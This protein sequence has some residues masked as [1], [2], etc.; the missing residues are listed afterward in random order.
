MFRMV[1]F[2]LLIALGIS[3]TSVKADSKSDAREADRVVTNWEMKSY[4]SDLYLM[5][6]FIANYAYAK[7]HPNTVFADDFEGVVKWTLI[8]SL[9]NQWYIGTA[10]ANGGLKSLYISDDNGVNNNY[11]GSNT[12]SHAVS[13]P[14][15]LA[16]GNAN[17]VLSFDWRAEGELVNI[18]YY[19]YLSVW[20]VPENYIPQAGTVITT[21]SSGGILVSR[22]LLRQSVFKKSNFVVDLSAFANQKVKIIF[23]WVNDGFT[24][25]QPPAAIDNVN[26]SLITCW[27]PRNMVIDNITE[28]SA[29]AQWDGPAGGGATDFEIYIS[30]LEVSPVYN[31][32]SVIAVNNNTSVNFNNL[33]A[34][35]A[36]NVWYRTVCGVTNKSYWQ[37][38]VSFRTPCQPLDLPFGETFNMDSNTIF[39]WKIV[40]A[41]N[42]GTGPNGY[43][44]WKPLSVDL[45]GNRVMYFNGG[46][47]NDDWLISPIFNMDVTKT[48]KLKY[49]YKTTSYQDNEFEVLA[50]DSGDTVTN[51]TQIIVPKKI[52]RNGDWKEQITYLTNIGGQLNFAWHVTDTTYAEVSLNNVSLEQVECIE[53]QG[54]SATN[55]KASQVTLNWHDVTN[56]SWQ[57]RI[58]GVDEVAPM[59]SGVTTTTNEVVVSQDYK[60]DPLTAATNYVYYVRALCASGNFG[61][62]IGP[63][64]FRTACNPVNLPLQEG[65]NSASTTL[66]C[67]VLLDHNDDGTSWG[68]NRWAIKD[69]GQYEGNGV[70]RFYAGATSGDHDD[71]LISPTIKMTGAIYSISY[72]YKTSNYNDSEF[73]LLLAED[74][75]NLSDFTTVLS[76]TEKYTNAGYLKKTVY[77]QGVVADVKLAWHVVGSGASDLYID[78]VTIERVDCIA[79][80]NYSVLIEQLGINTATLS[81]SDNT[82]SSWEYYVQPQGAGGPPVSSGSL[83]SQ[84][85]VVVTRTNGVGGANLQ[86]NTWYEFY[87]R[88]SCGP[89][90]NSLW[91]GPIAFKTQCAAV[92]LPFWEGFNRNSS[93]LDCWAIVDNNQDGDDSGWQTTNMWRVETFEPFQGDQYMHFYGSY[94]AT[95]HDDWLIS[96]TFILDVNKFYRLKY[97][98]KTSNYG[99]NDFKVLLSTTG[100]D[101]DKFTTILIDKQGDKTD[102]WVQGLAFVGNTGGSVNLAWQVNSDGGNAYLSLDNVFFEEVIGCPEPLDLGAK[103]EL[104]N[105]VTIYW[106]DAFGSNWEYFVQKK[107]GATPTTNGTLTNKKE[108]TI[109]TDQSA[110]ALLANAQYEFY[111]RTVCGNGAYSVW[112][113]PFVFRTDC[114]AFA[115]PYWEG[116]NG[117]STTINCWT[118]RDSE[119]EV[120][121]L[122]MGLPLTSNTW[123][124]VDQVTYEGSHAMYFYRSYYDDDSDA[125]LIS[126]RIR[127]DNNKIYR[128][129]YHFRVPEEYED[130]AY[131]VL[132]SNSGIEP[133]DFTKKILDGEYI[134]FN[135]TE[136]KIFITN[137]SGEVNI[138]WR[139]H[140]EESKVVYIDNVFVEEVIGCPEPLELDVDNIESKKATLLWSDAFN[141]TSWEYFVQEEG[142]GIPLTNGT[143]TA[144]KQNDITVDHSGKSL[145]PNTDYE[146][147]V[148]TV[149]IAGPHS[150]WAGP[151]KFQTLCDR[152]QTP[153]WDGFNTDTKTARCWTMVDA[154]YD[155]GGYSSPLL[156]SL[157]PYE[158]YE[159]NRGMSVS[160]WD[161]I[162][163]NQSNSWLISPNIVMDNSQYVLKYHYSTMS[164]YGGRFEVLLSSTPGSDLDLFDRVIVP[165]EHYYTNQSWQ[166]RVVFFNGVNATINLAWHM[167]SI[168][169]SGINLDNVFLKKIETCPE[170]YYVKVINATPTAIDVS[171]SQMGTVAEWEIIV[172]N[173][174]QD[175][176]AIPVTTKTV[177][178]LPQTTITGLDSAKL[179]KI[180]V[181]AKCIDGN[182]YSDWSTVVHGATRIGGS[183]NC[184]GAVRISVNTDQ[185]CDQ[186][187]MLSFFG[188]DLSNKPEPD[189]EFTNE[190]RKDVW[191]TFTAIHNT[192]VLTL[193]DFFSLSDSHFPYISVAVYD[194]DC[195]L[196]HDQAL[197]CYSI[198]GDGDYSMIENLII[199]QKYYLRFA[200]N[201][202]V[203]D[204]FLVKACISTP[205]FIKVD[206]S[207]NLYTVEQLVKEVLVKTD[208]DLVSNISYRTGTHFN[209]PNG[210]GYFE[211]NRSIFPF[212]NGI[213]LATNGVETAAGPS[214]QDQS[215]GNDAWLGD[216]DLQELLS[217][218]GRTDRNY[219]ASVIEF[220]FIPVTDTIKFDFVFASNEY[221]TFQC[222]YT[223]VFAFFLTDLETD[224]MTNLAVVP[225]TD[226]PVSVTTIRNSKYLPGRCESQNEEY[227]DTFYGTLGEPHKNNPINYFGYTVPMTAI[228]A[229]EYGKK[230]RIKL[231]IADYI[232]SRYNSAVFLKG[233]SFD[234]G[235]VDLGP[236]LLVETG[237]ALCRGESKII[238]TGVITNDDISI[239]W[240]KDDVLI[241]DA[242]EPDF[243]VEQSGIYTVVVKYHTL[244]CEGSGRVEVE[245]YP[246]IS[247]VVEKP[248]E[249]SLC[250][251]VLGTMILDLTAVQ[252]QMLSKVANKDVYAFKYYHTREDAELAV[253]AIPK[254]EEY[255]FDLTQG[256]QRKYVVVE[257]MR[258]GCLEIFEWEL[259]LGA[260]EMPDTREDIRI[261]ATYSFPALAPNQ[262]YYTGK[263]ATGD[264]YQEGDELSE[265]G[266]HKIYVLQDNGNGCYEEISYHIT[267]TEAVTADLFDDVELEC[268]VYQ[269]KPLS[270]LNHYYSEPSGQ[271]REL[272]A[273]TEVLYSQT[274][275]VY[276]VSDDGICI[277]ESSFQVTYRDCP[278][279]KGIS[280]NG[281]GKNDRFDLSK[282]GVSSMVIYNR[283]GSE[284]Y[285]FSGAYTD[286]WYGQNKAGK[287]LPDG[288]YY[289]VVVAHGKIRTGWVQIN[290]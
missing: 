167:N 261:C 269:L 218:N 12:C 60:N 211:A 240:Y 179:Y 188:A 14:I 277:D 114:D 51:F 231:A 82:N 98:Y 83:S 135:Y 180:Y 134:S 185:S 204:D 183:N 169:S 48:Y 192:H 233:G 38:P 190:L 19:D 242:V 273:G 56:S 69:S 145:Q 106:D 132:I 257:D 177:T 186:F 216:D 53:P 288:T 163:Q 184:D 72:Y 107:G 154:N 101:I 55:I 78:W 271:G 212:E 115:T 164:N 219:N 87:V 136:K 222:G 71:W 105:A 225:G 7:Q 265:V 287:Q 49:F 92:V 148:R 99:Q 22:A 153:F 200:I 282:H 4:S 281:D 286:Q 283:Y 28:T 268:E 157:N 143:I 54:M 126:P 95:Q 193:S 122:T 102:N 123:N 267:I 8:N 140:G 217:Q 121:K 221:G 206:A 103:D 111:V 262:F 166:E 198:W 73:E 210:L 130:A 144:L 10:V 85:S 230:Y 201:I 141:A 94:S 29:S 61:E 245:I 208:C 90:K 67:W 161:W 70:A 35:Q 272:T 91:I 21:S 189:C 258:T 191:A 58:Q 113:G 27:A 127:F 171:W 96:P 174:D 15:T 223:D 275:Y 68:N 155:D 254:P 215:D 220:D 137:S 235:K 151:Y 236:D 52:Y 252:R 207:G 205:H 50:S 120:T 108:N 266:L 16:G 226:I 6:Y 17:Y 2:Y 289:Y 31:P 26:L 116:F 118:I 75:F 93:T 251:Y 86:P 33:V 1:F 232:D 247:A 124:Q 5:P 41:N 77:V 65:F 165:L 234:L 255:N 285:T 187:V 20:I 168:G 196:I 112:S 228:S 79:P 202:S 44:L 88:S 117:N 39:C 244:N 40:D 239:S 279:P 36:Y 263:A 100:V 9:V 25:N 149:C 152:Y 213:I 139:V 229:V 160:I 238:K 64:Y 133:A 156:W 227:F 74:Q 34:N 3:L 76:A 253:Q 32:P 260:G 24:Q 209:N 276:A 110:A 197:E 150:I 290:R 259:N 63:F 119:G 37:G 147:Y 178:G 128:L 66:D 109:S 237:N 62:W 125:W 43:N 59:I 46:A 195:S 172:V 214:D 159:G 250:R 47:G 158:F 270:S 142:L 256:N 249:L 280:P 13:Q 57:Y 284:V 224:V 80:D 175:E 246:A 84:K 11:S 182:S 176:S 146:F 42:D 30:N 241:P 23:Q 199:G 18:T 81:W 278:I 173:Y 248:S 274:I 243:E 138:A 89:G 181:R 170:P 203:A 131:E 45:L 194:Q 264:S 162:G 104:K 129:K 97:H